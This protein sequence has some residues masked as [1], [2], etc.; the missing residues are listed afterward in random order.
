VVNSPKVCFGTTRQHAKVG[1]KNINTF[2]YKNHL[3]KFYRN[4]NQFL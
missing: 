4:E 1:H 3:G 2:G